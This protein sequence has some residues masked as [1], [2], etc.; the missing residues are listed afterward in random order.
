MQSLLDRGC[1]VDVVGSQSHLEIEDRIGEQIDASIK[2][3]AAMGI[4]CAFTEL[5][6]D[7]VSRKLYWNPQTRPQALAMNPYA[8]GAPD[9]VLEKQAEV[10]RQFFQAVA[11]NRKQVDRVTFWGITDAHS[12]LNHWPWKRINHALLFDRDGQPK[13]AYHAVATSLTDTP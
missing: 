13:P 8:D 3:C 2:Q 5:D 1:R 10:Y 12:W 11:A 9:E 4:R 7:V 6:V